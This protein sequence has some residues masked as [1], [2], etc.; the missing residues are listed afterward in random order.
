[1]Q[2]TQFQLFGVGK[3][4]LIRSLFF[5]S[6]ALHLMRPEGSPKKKQ[7]KKTKSHLVRMLMAGLTLP[8]GGIWR[9]EPGQMVNNDK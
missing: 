3:L 9:A 4:I 8:T 1:M 7:K 5:G 6:E 2:A